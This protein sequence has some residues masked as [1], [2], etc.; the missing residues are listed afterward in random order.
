L[1]APLRKVQVP[2][3]IEVTLTSRL[4]FRNNP[5]TAM[6]LKPMLLATKETLVPA[7]RVAVLA[8]DNVTVV[9]VI[10]ET[11]ALAP[12]PVPVTVIPGRIPVA[13]A[14]VIVVAAFTP[15]AVV[16]TDE[17]GCNAPNGAWLALVLVCV[18]TVPSA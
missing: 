2:E 1:E 13:D 15:V 4:V 10:E 5:V 8:T 18:G 7:A 16:E 3:G 14:T 12:I 6:G 9:P 17:R 11:V